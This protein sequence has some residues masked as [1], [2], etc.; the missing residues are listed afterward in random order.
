MKKG[1]IAALVATAAVCASTVGGALGGGFV[2]PVPA[3]AQVPTD[4]VIVAGNF[5]AGPRDEVFYYTP[6]AGPDEVW[7][8]SLEGEGARVDTVGSIRVDGTYKPLVGDYDADGFDEILWYA[9][10]FAPDYMWNFTSYSTVRSRTYPVNGSY[11]RP[12][13]GDFTGDRA[14][15]ILWY[16]P[17]FGADYFWEYNAGGGFTSRRADSNGHYRPVS[18]SIGNDRT[19]DIFWYAPGAAADFLW[20]YTPGSTAFRSI[21]QTVNGVYQPFSLDVFREGAGNEDIFWYGLGLAPDSIWDWF[22]GTRFDHD[23]FGGPVDGEHLT[24]AGDFLGDG[25]EDVVFENGSEMWLRE[26]RFIEPGLVDVHDFLFL[27][28]VAAADSRAATDGSAGLSSATAQQ[29][30]EATISRR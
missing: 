19:D 3:G 16:N 26:H 10:G 30:G 18:G 27:P 1:R 11:S 2:A 22:Q 5:Y 9:P 13:V 29:A 15:D 6:G 12:V 24:A 7:V 21:R 14:D 23:L 25:S 4:H 20:D 17:G 8:F 28:S